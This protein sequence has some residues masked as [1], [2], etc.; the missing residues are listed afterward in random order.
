MQPKRN[1]VPQEVAKEILYLRT[2][3]RNADEQLNARGHC[4][5]WMQR[6]FV[7]LQCDHQEFM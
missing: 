5:V 3:K 4:G 2:E 7:C 1:D 6:M